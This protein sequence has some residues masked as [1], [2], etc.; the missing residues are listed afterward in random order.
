MHMQHPAQIPRRQQIEEHDCAGEHHP[1]GSLRHH[2]K[3]AEQI[4]KPV[5]FMHK[6]KQ[7][8]GHKKQQGGIRYGSLAHVHDHD[9]SAH[10]KAGPE[11]GPGTELPGSRHRCHHNSPNSHQR[12]GN[13]GCEFRKASEQFQGTNQQPVKNR[14]LVVPVFIVNTGRKIFVK[15][16]H[17][18]GRLRIHRFVRIQQRHAVNAKQNI[19]TDNH[20][21]NYKS[22]K[23]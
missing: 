21:Q 1:D 9:R 5:F 19:K 12:R 15:T 10:H 20:Q 14:R 4:H 8:A 16:D 7:R 6:A 17:L 2:R 3:A 22:L 23:R 13:T 18:L 11:A